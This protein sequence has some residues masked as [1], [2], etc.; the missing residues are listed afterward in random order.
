ML[1]P[2]G[3]GIGIA[4]HSNGVDRLLVAVVIGMCWRLYVAKKMEIGGDNGLVESL[5]TCAL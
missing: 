5:V 2:G 4:C 3:E 1:A